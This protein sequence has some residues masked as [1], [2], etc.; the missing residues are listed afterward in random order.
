MEV[1]QMGLEEVLELLQG[2]EEK[3]SDLTRDQVIA[4]LRNGFDL[5]NEELDF[6]V[7][8]VIEVKM[9]ESVVKDWGKLAVCLEFIDRVRGW[10]LPVTD[11]GDMTGMPAAMSFDMVCLVWTQHG[12]ALMLADS[13]F[14]RK[15]A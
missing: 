11:P 13:A 10:D 9:S 3:G 2:R 8:D 7:G 14:Y 12:F 15:V 5:L 6:G 1:R 4:R